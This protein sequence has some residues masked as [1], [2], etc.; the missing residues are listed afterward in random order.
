MFHMPEDKRLSRQDK[1]HIFEEGLSVCRSL[2][3]YTFMNDFEQS[4]R[5]NKQ[6]LTDYGESLIT[7]ST[8]SY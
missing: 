3:I 2:S 5:I 4:F 8:V 6:V 7:F 1:L